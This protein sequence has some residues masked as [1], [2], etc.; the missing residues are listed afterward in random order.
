MKTKILTLLPLTLAIA[1][2]CDPQPKSSPS[3]DSA[4]SQKTAATDGTK[5]STSSTSTTSTE[6]PPTETPATAPKP[7]TKVATADSPKEPTAPSDPVPADIKT[8]GYEY[9]GVGHTGAID[10]E[11][12]MST[13]KDVITGSQTVALKEVKDGKAVYSID[14]TGG[15]ASL[16]TEEWTLSKE[17]VFTSKS[18]MMDVGD[19]A[20]ELPAVPK[21]GMT[22]KVHTK[23]DQ[24]TVKMDMNITFKIVGK[25]S[26][27]TKGGKFDDALLVEQDG[28][29]TL[30]SKKVRT[31][32]QN[33]YVKGL[34]L[35]KANMKTTNPDGKTESLTIQETKSQ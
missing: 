25:Q 18:S 8:E 33:W 31:V 23:S 9:S 3:T 12:T 26:I 4:P 16:G 19:K 28:V 27:S 13:T 5:P 1:V 15:L 14:R 6:K 24:P 29:G 10:M 35:V 7:D 34:G 17:G 30:Q 32:S 11:L 2:G 20:M 22:W 21:P